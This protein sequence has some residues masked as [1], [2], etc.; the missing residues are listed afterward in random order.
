MSFS[1]NYAQW[2]GVVRLIE[3]F[4]RKEKDTTVRD[5][6]TELDALTE[7]IARYLGEKDGLGWTPDKG[8]LDRFLRGVAKN[9]YAAHTKRALRRASPLESEPSTEY[10]SEQADLADKRTLLYDTVW[11][12]TAGHPEL[13]QL[14]MAIPETNGHDIDEQPAEMLGIEKTEVRNRRKRLRRLI[15]ELEPGTRAEL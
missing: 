13:R 1:P 5:G 15:R 7:A 4:G 10:R 6:Y 12:R 2:E 14:L 9:V 3:E 11:A 8:N